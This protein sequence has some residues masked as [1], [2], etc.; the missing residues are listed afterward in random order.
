[1]PQ[2]IYLLDDTIKNNIIFDEN[3]ELDILRAN[4]I[5]K[6]TNLLNFIE[7]LPNKYDER[8]GE[9]ANR[10]S[11]GQ[12]KRLG[13]AR[14]LYKNRQIL[15]LDEPTSGLDDSNTQ[16]LMNLIKEISKNH[17]VII[18]S[19]NLESIREY[20]T[21]VLWINKSKFMMLDDTDK[22]IDKYINF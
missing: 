15:I 21:K 2:D 5:L 16:S 19:H 20:A 14:C 8:I 11:G 12:I 9:K 7:K 3:S 1:M 18:V 17:T 13:L 10:L 4:K 22:V 6:S